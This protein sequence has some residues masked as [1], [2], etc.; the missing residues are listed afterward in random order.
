MTPHLP[1]SS[2]RVAARRLPALAVLLGVAAALLGACAST[3]PPTAQLAVS[4]AALAN[5]VSAG[6]PE[7]AADDLRT[8][9]GKLD[10]A[11]VAML[12]KDYD[13]ARNLAR[14]AEVDAQLAATRARSAKAQKA[15]EALQEGSRVLR[16]EIGRKTTP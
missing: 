4:N 3:P 12:A 9:R 6:A 2:H 8:A 13:Q 7:L 10:R 15:A 16:E 1:K 5:A 14:E 11:N